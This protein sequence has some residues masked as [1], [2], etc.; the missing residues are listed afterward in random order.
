MADF[1]ETREDLGDSNSD[2]GTGVDAWADWGA[3]TT[4]ASFDTSV[5]SFSG[6]LSAQNLS[7]KNSAKN[8]ASNF[9]GVLGQSGLAS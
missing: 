1:Y 2:D 3:P 6:T 7:G 5:T 9:S 4:G 8:P